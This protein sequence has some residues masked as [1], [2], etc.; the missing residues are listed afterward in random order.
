MWPFN[1]IMRSFE[2]VNNL[3]DILGEFRKKSFRV[4]S[5]VIQYSIVLW[6]Y[7]HLGFGIW[8]RWCRFHFRND[9]FFL[10]QDL[11]PIRSQWC[12]CKYNSISRMNGA[13]PFHFS[14]IYIRT[15]L[16]LQIFYLIRTR[17]R[18]GYFCMMT[19]HRRYINNNIILW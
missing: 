7:N 15:M 18:F 16:T 17:I 11:Y 6:C 19:R 5:K 1:K 12:G 9:I 14:S 3:E 8:F 4:L 13:M 2:S 10:I